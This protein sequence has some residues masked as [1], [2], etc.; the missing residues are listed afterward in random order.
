MPDAGPSHILLREDAADWETVKPERFVLGVIHNVTSATR[1]LDLLKPFE[2]DSRVQ[3]LFAC[4]GSSA[5]TEGLREF[6]TERKLPCISWEEAKREKFD[7]AVSSSRG[8]DLHQLNAPLVGAPH[9][10]G[11]NKYL[12][13]KPEAGSRKPEAGSRKPE[14]FGLGAEWL[15]HDGELIPS[16]IVLSHDEQRER[17]RRGCPEAVPFSVVA[18]DPC[19]DQLLAGVPFRDEY[20]AALGVRPGQKLLVLTSTWKDQSLLGAHRADLEIIRRSLAE[21][22][23]DEYRVLHAVHP[24]AWFTHGGHQIREWFEPFLRAG[25]LLPS[26]E[27]DIWKAALV[28]A[29]AFIGDHGSLTLYAAALGVPGLLGA[30][31]EDTVAEGSPMDLLGRELPRVTRHEPLGRQLQRAAAAQAG[32]QRERLAEIGALVTSRPLQAAGLLRSLYYERMKLDEPQHPAISRPVALPLP[33]PAE[34][35]Q[36]GAA[37]VYADMQGGRLRRYPAELQGS[38][39]HH[40]PDPYLVA[41]YG[42]PDPRWAHAADVILARSLHSG[43]SWED[44]ARRVFRR[45][46]GCE[47]VAFPQEATGCLAFTRDRLQRLT[48]QWQDGAPSWPYDFSVAASALYSTLTSRSASSVRVSVVD[49][50][51]PAVLT[52]SR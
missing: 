16:A 51:P 41:A 5:F 49:G 48:A 38:L 31:D 52:I 24:N 25:L 8:G 12:S 46:P 30:F 19:M 39:T 26:P 2:G 18:G 37:A 36:P 23:A 50:L 7:L 6:I 9:G 45:H 42:E 11:Y 15:V 22:P 21:L 14:A 4:T 28:A 3:V 29:D 1:L 17:L 43:E 33:L 44:A 47:L 27:T 13:R 34:R 32:P 10:A 40:L 20:R 35:R